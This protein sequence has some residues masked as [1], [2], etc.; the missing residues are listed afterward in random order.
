MRPIVSRPGGKSRLAHIILQYVPPHNIYVEPFFGGGSVFFAKRPV[1][2]EI[3]NDKDKELMD[4]YRAYRSPKSSIS[5]VNLR[6]SRERFYHY[7]KI[8]P[9]TPQETVNRYLYLNK[10]GFGGAGEQ[11][12]PVFAKTRGRGGNKSGIAL[13]KPEHKTRLKNAQMYITDWRT[14]ANRYKGYKTA[15]VYL[16]PPYYETHNLYKHKTVDPKDVIGITRGAKAK[17]LISYNDHPYI[18]RLA[19]KYGLHIK[20]VHTS[21][22][23]NSKS[24]NRDKT[25]LLIANYPLIKQNKK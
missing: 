24:N 25:E 17:I 16:D 14:I 18:I 1:K 2:T 9:K 15:F 4:F 19:R 6:A 10:R 23:L 21:Y 3:I 22:S 7:K 11:Y 12:S 5:K 20:R 13:I 8:K